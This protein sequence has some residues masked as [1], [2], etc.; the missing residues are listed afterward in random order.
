MHELRHAF[1]NR[2]HLGRGKF[3]VMQR[4]GCEARN[5]M[6]GIP[7]LLSGQ[8]FPPPLRGIRSIWFLFKGLGGVQIEMTPEDPVF[9]LKS[10]T[11]TLQNP[12]MLI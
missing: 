7:F 5:G 8:L 12:G 6:S 4:I 11:Q 10:K 2:I 3:A 1:C 9:V